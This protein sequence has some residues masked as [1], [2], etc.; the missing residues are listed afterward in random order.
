LPY[1]AKDS[2]L[3]RPATRDDLAALEVLVELSGLFPPDGLGEIGRMMA[4]QLRGDVG[5]LPDTR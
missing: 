3:I 2:D 4:D 5:C 1:S